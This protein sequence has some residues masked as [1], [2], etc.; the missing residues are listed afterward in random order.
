MATVGFPIVGLMGSPDSVSTLSGMTSRCRRILCKA[1]VERLQFLHES[2]APLDAKDPLK[3]KYME[4]IV[5]YVTLMR[6][7]PLLQRLGN[8]ETL[9]TKWETEWGVHRAKQ[10]DILNRLVND[11]SERMLVT[12]VRG[13]KNV[14]E[15]IMSLNKSIQW[16]NQSPEM[17]ELK[18][19]TFSRVSGYWNRE[20]LRMFDW[21]I[22]IDDVEFEDMIGTQGTFGYVSRG[23]WTHDGERTDV[24]IKQLFPEVTASDDDSFLRL[25]EHWNSLP[26]NKH[27]LKLYRGSHV[28]SPQFYVCENAPNGNLADFL[29]DGEHGVLFWRLFKQ[30]ALGLQFLHSANTVHGGLKCNNILVGTNFTTKLADFTFTSVR[31]L[32]AGLSKGSE[33][34]TDISV[35]W[36]PKE[37]LEQAGN[38][39]PRFES[40]IYSLAMC[41]IEAK[42]GAIPFEM[43]DDPQTAMGKIMRGEEYP[44]PEQI[45][46]EEWAFIS[47]LC[48]PD[49]KK[50]PSLDEVLKEISN[51]HKTYYLFLK[52]NRRP[53]IQHGS[54]HINHSKAQ[55]HYAHKW[56]VYRAKW[57]NNDVVV[58]EVPVV[59]LRRFLK[60]VNTWHGL[61]H[62]NVAP[63][64][65]ANHRKDPLFIVSQ[66]AAKGELV[67]YL[68]REKNQGRDL[69]WRK[70]KEV[71]AGLAYL[72]SQG[73]VHGDLKGDSI[74]VN[75][76][77]IAMLTNFG[78]RSL[79]K[80][81]DKYGDMA[82]R[83]PELAIRSILTPTQ[84]SDVYLLGMS[85]IEAVTLKAPLSEYNNAEIRQLLH[86][87]EV[88]VDKPDTM[89]EPQWKL[90]K[91]MIAVSPDDRPNLSDVVQK[92]QEFADDEEMEE[93][94][95]GSLM[96]YFCELGN[97]KLKFTPRTT[98]EYLISATRHKLV[99]LIAEAKTKAPFLTKPVLLH[100][101]PGTVSLL[102]LEVSYLTYCYDI[103][104]AGKSFIVASIAAELDRDVV[105]IKSQ[106]VLSH[107]LGETEAHILA[108]FRRAARVNPPAKTAIVVVEEFESLCPAM[109]TDGAQESNSWQSTVRQLLI[110][111]LEDT[112]TPSSEFFGL[113][114]VATTNFSDRVDTAVRDRMTV[115]FVPHPSKT[116]IKIELAELRCDLESNL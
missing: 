87:S 41:M 81:K 63:F 116:I 64:Y 52:K 46:V 25:L 107:R 101:P 83:A 105:K 72:H 100:G 28:S 60:E 37:V 103:L 20:G 94:T 75:D 39:A 30:V 15:A 111:L 44:R 113:V 50:R 7:K 80:M 1:V 53:M 88:K 40:D 71:V 14:Q 21:F 29:A 73:V 92:L 79:V 48:D 68:K 61:R 93:A 6:R 69:V 78:L 13:D 98:L 42:T 85:I 99:E 3:K 57:A 70:L 34:A 91:Q 82:W 115:L 76:N 10:Y 84:K 22:P 33:K 56:R 35:R 89:T 49:Y 11:A 108:C 51:I 16:R 23:I 32:S 27:I 2:V 17:V 55:Q 95:G 58:K 43:D 26:P 102:L 77:G 59:E 19:K 47:R 62:A 110:T 5:K 45:S 24:V 65:G 109:D 86:Q 114:I 97:T 112:Q 104:G 36:K 38:E 67:E 31:S 90:V 18:K 8:C 9:M 12:E 74:V 66:Y 96:H 54:F 4:I 106:D